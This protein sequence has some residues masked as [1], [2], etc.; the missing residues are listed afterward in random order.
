MNFLLREDAS[1]VGP[2]SEDPESLVSSELASG[3]DLI[4]EAPVRVDRSARLWRRRTVHTSSLDINRLERTKRAFT[5]RHVP[6]KAMV[7]LIDGPVRP[8]P[9]DLV[10]AR[11]DR[12]GNHRRLELTGG[13]RAW[14]H[15]GDEIVVAYADRYA[16]DQFESYVPLD[17]QPT[18][19]VASGGVAS[20]VRTKSADVRRATEITPLGLIGDERGTSLNLSD[21]GL[22]PVPSAEN[23]LPTL[24]VIGT[25][26]N[27]GKTT[28]IKQLV[29]GLRDGGHRPGVTKVTGT[30][31]GGD[32]WVMLDAGAQ[33]MLDFTDAGLASTFGVDM[34]VVE[35]TMVN[36][37][38]HLTHR[39]SGSILIEVADGLL[40]YETAHLLG[41]EAF[42][43]RV[44]GV[45]FAAAD[46]MGAIAGVARL[47]ELGLPVVAVAGRL[48]RSPLAVAETQAE[49]G[50][51]VLT[52]TELSDPVTATALLGPPSPK[53]EHLEDR[54]TVENPQVVID[55][56]RRDGVLEVSGPVA[57]AGGEV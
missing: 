6:V 37:I 2:R 26:M 32:Y 57:V 36:L 45:V 49:C 51:P 17:L 34:P 7:S 28:T 20:S 43:E 40:Q 33:A 53:L 15:P 23:R 39:G 14:M 11:V 52:L 47:Q 31:S 5:T 29:L 21:F 10:L 3:L 18:Q 8:R 54:F 4:S 1:V 27:S 48:T 9:G 19:L 50:V 22:R 16:P 41:S 44:D 35:Q 55:L 38:D 56:R 42:Q 30:G 13:R 24:A 25:S 12:L 46:A